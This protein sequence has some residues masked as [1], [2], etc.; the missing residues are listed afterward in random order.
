MILKFAFIAASVFSRENVVSNFGNIKMPSKPLVPEYSLVEQQITY[1]II[2]SSLMQSSPKKIH[3]ELAYE[4]SN[5][6]WPDSG[7]NMFNVTHLTYE[8]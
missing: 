2:V 6:V 5:F 7:K 8:D 4:F 3:D 1:N